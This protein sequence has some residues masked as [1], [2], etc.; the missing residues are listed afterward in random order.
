MVSE[1]YW[2][3]PHRW[4]K[5]RSGAH[6]FLLEA[7]RQLGECWYGDIWRAKRGF[8][9]RAGPQLPASPADADLATLERAHEA[10]AYWNYD[11]RPDISW[12]VLFNDEG[13]AVPDYDCPKYQFS[14]E[15]WAKARET[16]DHGLTP[17]EV[18]ACAPFQ[19]IA[20]KIIDAACA[21]SK[22]LRMF[23][24]PLDR[25]KCEV[26]AQEHWNR[27]WDALWP[28]FAFGQTNANDPSSQDPHGSHSIFVLA[29]DLKRLTRRRRHAAPKDIENLLTCCTNDLAAMMRHPK[30]NT[31]RGY[32]DGAS[33]KYPTLGWTQFKRCWADARK[34]TPV[35]VRDS[36]WDNPGVRK[37]GTTLPIVFQD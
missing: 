15:E 36:S 37:A 11:Y 35:G 27:D 8:F 7:V 29:L 18:T 23:T 26:M 32:Y 10:L 33:A 17:K 34:A 1:E 6:V 3:Q 30:Q 24:A 22:P 5:D 12:G 2:R 25:V 21:T 9:R 31:Q 16:C 4:P 28:R 20:N 14:D 19:D 13:A